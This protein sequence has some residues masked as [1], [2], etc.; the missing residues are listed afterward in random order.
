MDPDNFPLLDRD[1]FINAAN[2][3]GAT[4]RLYLTDS[5]YQHFINEGG[6]ST[7]GDLT[8]LKVIGGTCG[9]F[10]DGSSSIL[11]P[12]A[13]KLNFN[14]NNH[15]LEFRINSFSGF[16]PRSNAAILPIELLYF[17][18]NTRDKSN[19]L[20]WASS[21]EESTKI[22]E[23]ERL[24]DQSNE[25]EVIGQL[26]AAGNSQ[27]LVTYQWEDHFPL[28][29]AYYRIKTIDSDGS[30]QYSDLIS[31]KRESLDLLVGKVFPNP[32]TNLFT[33]DIYASAL[34]DVQ[35]SIF[36]INGQLLQQKQTIVNTGVTRLEVDLNNYPPGIYLFKL[37][38]GEQQFIQK[39]QKE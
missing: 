11:D 25:W 38:I 8:L 39:I 34:E 7:L 31:L 19:F 9:N 16:F 33:T 30:F 26:A 2:N 12:I 28:P 15:M 32:T 3:N 18:G 5:E 10:N 4:V 14:G 35:Y 24:L 29:L 1:W 22:H 6:I 20:E 13:Y 37:S 17:K 36:N 21:L 27:S 23:I